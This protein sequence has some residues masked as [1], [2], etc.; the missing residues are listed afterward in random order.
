MRKRNVVVGE[1]F[2]NLTV[3]RE[4]DRRNGRR[5]LELKC[6]CGNVTV[7]SLSNL[8]IG[9]TRSCGC[10]RKGN[11]R[12]HGLRNHPLYKLWG[13]IKSRCKSSDPHKLNTYKSIM[14]CDEWAENPV[15]F[16]EWAL[17][18]GWKEGLEI[19]RIDNSKDYSPKNCRFVTHRKNVLNRRVV[20][21]NNR[22]GYCGVSY[23]NRDKVW[24]WA[25]TV[26]GVRISG[27]TKTREEA[28]KKRD[29]YIIANDLQGSYKL[30]VEV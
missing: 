25:I 12:K 19:D 16:I 2:G 9:M 13:S 5:H 17:S 7:V 20:F 23:V 1:R 24:R 15:S 22:S 29:E 21:R 30:Q 3:L 4:V 8:V 14:M 10:L 27:Y 6:D 28:V 26:E 11:N 18:N